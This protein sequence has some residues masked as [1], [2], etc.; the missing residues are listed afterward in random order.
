[1]NINRKE[2]DYQDKQGMIDGLVLPADQFVASADTPLSASDLNYELTS[3]GQKR[4]MTPKETAQYLR[5]SLSWVYKN[6]DQLGGRKLGGSLLFP[7]KEDLYEFL[8]CER[9][10]VEVRL[11]PQRN[12]VHGN[13]VHDQKRGQESRGRKKKGVGKP[14]TVAGESDR[15]GLLGLG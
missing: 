11:H 14:K 12:Q 6:A 15:H 2:Q 1:M 8:F 7:A 9:K 5:K 13:L 3:T 4:I 10:G